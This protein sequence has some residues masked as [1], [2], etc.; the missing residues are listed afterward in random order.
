LEGFVANKRAVVQEERVKTF[1][2]RLKVRGPKISSV[3]PGKPVR[4]D[5]HG[6][7]VMAA[8][9]ARKGFLVRVHFKDLIHP[10]HIKT[11]HD[12]ETVLRLARTV[13]QQT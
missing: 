2:A 9:K 1:C 7:Q 3:T 8:E 4:V 6:D 12:Q 11:S 10:I 5:Q 13:W